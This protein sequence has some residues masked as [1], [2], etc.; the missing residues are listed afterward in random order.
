M[1]KFDRISVFI[2]Y[3]A[4]AMCVYIS[5]RDLDK[6]FDTDYITDIAIIFLVT[7]TMLRVVI[8]ENRIK[9]IKRNKL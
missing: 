1:S 7:C 6:C 5:A 8:L 4:L 2:N 9:N 3:F